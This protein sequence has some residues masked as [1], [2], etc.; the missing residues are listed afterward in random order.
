M[1]LAENDEE[2]KVTFDGCPVD[3]VNVEY[4]RYKKF[5]E[6]GI[7]SLELIDSGIY[8]KMAEEY[9]TNPAYAY[10]QIDF[11]VDDKWLI[12]EQKDESGS[13]ILTEMVAISRINHI[14]IYPNEP[15]N[16]L[17]NRNHLNDTEAE[18]MK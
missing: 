12:H 14:L 17:E 9:K 16:R 10:K 18:R 6:E 2:I 3:D 1:N 7:L 15:K 8:K 5:E 11:R 4:W 13:L